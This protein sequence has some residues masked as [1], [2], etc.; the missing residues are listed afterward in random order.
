LNTY[1]DFVRSQDPLMMQPNTDGNPQPGGPTLIDSKLGGVSTNAY[2]YI[3]PEFY[4]F[5]K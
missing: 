1:Q 2:S 4:Y 3:T 5:T